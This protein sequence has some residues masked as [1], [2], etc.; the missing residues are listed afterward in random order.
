MQWSKP[1][2]REITLGMEVTAYVN[3]DDSTGKPE[4]PPK[5]TE[6]ASPAPAPA[7]QRENAV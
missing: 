5:K 3:T 6:V 4:E 7:A 2:F 1:D